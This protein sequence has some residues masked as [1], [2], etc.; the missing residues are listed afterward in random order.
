V[1]G[2]LSKNLR[3]MLYERLADSG[4]FAPSGAGSWVSSRSTGGQLKMRRCAGW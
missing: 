4:W 2:A 3:Q 1:L